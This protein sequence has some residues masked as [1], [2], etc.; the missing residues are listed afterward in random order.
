[1]NKIAQTFSLSLL[2]AI[3]S[4]S[5]L[6]LQ[7]AQARIIDP[8][9]YTSLPSCAA[10]KVLDKIVSRFNEADRSL[11]RNGVRV[12]SITRSHEHA[13]NIYADSPI[14][15]RYCQAKAWMS[16]GRSRTMHYLIE[17]GMGLAGF[18]WEVEY[19]L[20]G[21]DRWHAYGGWCRVLRK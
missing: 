11:W 1:M 6:P 18:G 2:L 21:S 16:N 5:F 10:P 17:Q 3:S 15:R 12:R 7:Q 19:C 9:W 8:S 4:I 20:Y 14:N 13:Y